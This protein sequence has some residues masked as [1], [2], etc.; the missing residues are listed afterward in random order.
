M[1]CPVRFIQGRSYSRFSLFTTGFLANTRPREEAV[2]LPIEYA[3]PWTTIVDA[4]LAHLEAYLA[5]PLC[6]LSRLQA[7]FCNAG[8]FSSKL[9]NSNYYF[10]GRDKFF[11]HV[12][13][14]A[15]RKL[16]THVRYSSVTRSHCDFPNRCGRSHGAENKQF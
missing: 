15:V 16:P 8:S 3:V 11:V 9:T 1:S 5:F 10:L 7:S 2:G 6:S 13:S 4:K 14:Q 12:R